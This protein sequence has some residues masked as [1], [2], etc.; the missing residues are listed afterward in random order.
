[1]E[2]LSGFRG[3]DPTTPSAIEKAPSVAEGSLTAL[4]RDCFLERDSLKWIPVQAPVVL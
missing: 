3:R 1:M 4:K 2:N